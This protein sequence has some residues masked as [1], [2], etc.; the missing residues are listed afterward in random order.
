MR[1]KSRVCR[2][3]EAKA[4]L[5]FRDA[6]LTGAAHKKKVA[7]LDAAQRCTFNSL[8]KEAAMVRFTSAADAVFLAAACR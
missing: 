5:G 8:H 4:D 3:Q 6:C 1:R 7:L 2:G